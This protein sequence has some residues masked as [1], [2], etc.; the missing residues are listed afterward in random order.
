M[1]SFIY[2]RGGKYS[3]AVAMI[4]ENFSIQLSL[5]EGFQVA[6]LIESNKSGAIGVAEK[7]CA[8]KY[9]GCGKVIAQ[10][11]SRPQRFS[12]RSRLIIALL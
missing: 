5:S 7:N 9:A 11:K 4:A 2:S 8:A 6:R 12:L 1:K 3:S 10:P